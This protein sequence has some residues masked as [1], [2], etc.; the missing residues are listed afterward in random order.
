MDCKWL[1]ELMLYENYDSWNDY[2]EA[3]YRVFCEDFKDSAPIFENKVVKVRYQPIEYGK[4]EAF[5]HITCQDYA[6]EG[7]RVPDFRRCERIRWV[8]KFIENYK[9]NLEECEHCEG[10]KV[11]EEPYKSNSRVHILL[12]EERFMVVVE[13]REKYCLLITGFYFEHDHALEKKLKKYEQYIR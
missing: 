7:E 10:V 12:Q 2:Q 1:P 11:W 5:F 6:K 8:R 13:R 9:C 4:E 3:L